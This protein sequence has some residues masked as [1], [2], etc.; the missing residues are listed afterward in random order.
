[1]SLAS[2]TIR[3]WA[4]AYQLNEHCKKTNHVVDH[5]VRTVPFRQ[6][7]LGSNRAE[8]GHSMHLKT[9]LYLI[10]D[11]NQRAVLDTPSL[12]L[13]EGSIENPWILGYWPQASV[14]DESRSL[15]NQSTLRQAVFVTGW[16][17]C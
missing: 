11:S 12:T 16:R 3:L 15:D 13:G 14:W 8:L 1:M 17:C 4:L 6:R 5:V 7:E 10:R 2:W 9:D